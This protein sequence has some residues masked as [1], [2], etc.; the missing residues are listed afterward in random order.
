MQHQNI[1]LVQP[2]QV[3]LVA[4]ATGFIG[5]F[6][7][8]ELLQQGHQVFAL[9]RD[10]KRQQ[11]PLEN[12]LRSKAISIQ[13]LCII[14]ADITQPHLAISLEDWKKIQSVN[15][16]YNT[17]ALFAWHLSMMQA[18]TVNVEGALNLLVCVHQHCALQR[19]IHVSGYMLTIDTH[20]QQAGICVE[21]PEKTDWQ[22]VYRQLGA[23]EASKIEAHFAWI[24]Q[25]KQLAVD[26]TIIH[27]ATVL[28]DEQSGEI[29]SHQPV[30]HLI[31]LLKRQKMSAIPATAQHYFPLVSV[32]ELCRVMVYA[33][34]DPILSQQALLVANEQH[35]ALHQLIKMIAQQLHVKSPTRYIPIGVL[36]LLL[37]W[38]WLARQLEMSGEMLNFLRTEP[39]D[40]QAL[41]QFK[42]RYKIQS[43][44]LEMAI[45][46]TADWVGQTAP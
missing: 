34:T 10:L 28:G 24:Q 7:I 38:Q 36:K 2:T 4:G 35:I 26:W 6:L 27:P 19:A 44:H 15:V 23:Y 16:L 8:A 29:P 37:K 33:A 42:Q 45:R 32:D 1:N 41:K 17:S 11:I 25:A 5:R 31:D 46:R 20:L 40:L 21:Q 13:K 12:W 3:A 18:R 22:T 14:Q 9:M 43:S 39:L 30:A